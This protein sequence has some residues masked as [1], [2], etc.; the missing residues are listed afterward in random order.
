MRLKIL[1]KS[2]NLEKC[3]DLSTIYFMNYSSTDRK[4]KKCL[5]IKFN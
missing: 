5:K 4:K 2:I 3:N 1:Q